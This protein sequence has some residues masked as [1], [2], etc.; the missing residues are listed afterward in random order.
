MND[1]AHNSLAH[2]ARSSRPARIAEEGCSISRSRVECKGV[3]GFCSFLFFG[4]RN[5]LQNLEEGGEGGG[6]E[7]G[8]W[9]EG[10]DQIRIP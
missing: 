4:L 8:F 1:R 3:K 9:A 5:A 2:L 10:I 6:G 7:L